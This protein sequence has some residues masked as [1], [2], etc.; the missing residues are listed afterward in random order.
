[1]DDVMR[2]MRRISAIRPI[3][4]IAQRWDSCAT[5]DPFAQLCLFTFD[6]IVIFRRF[7]R[8]SF[9][10]GFLSDQLR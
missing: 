2:N 8:F 5:M 3:K 1:M 10:F 9:L 7:Q 4:N 6:D